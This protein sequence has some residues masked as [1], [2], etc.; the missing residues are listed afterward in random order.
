MT[1]CDLDLVSAYTTAMAMLRVPDWSSARPVTDL[2]QLAQVDEGMTFARVRFR[3]PDETRF[4]SLPCR[5][6]ERGLVYPLSGTSW[7][8]GPELAV[9]GSDDQVGDP[10]VSTVFLQTVA[11]ADT[12]LHVVQGA[13]HGFTAEQSYGDEAIRVTTDWLVSRLG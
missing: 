10:D 1:L 11:S 4:P 13:D 5:A 2:A 7:C 12:T 3:F 6:G 9:V 8:T